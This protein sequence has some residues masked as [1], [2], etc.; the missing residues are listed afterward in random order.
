MNFK[1]QW[2]H[3][4][5]TSHKFSQL[6]S[7]QLGI[8]RWFRFKM[9]SS[10]PVAFVSESLNVDWIR[11]LTDFYHQKC[12]KLRIMLSSHKLWQW[13]E[14]ICELLWPKKAILGYKH[15]M[16]LNPFSQ[17]EF[18]FFWLVRNGKRE[19]CLKALYFIRNIVMTF[20]KDRLS[21][22]QRR[23]KKSR[24]TDFYW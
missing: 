12:I 2:N 24:L 1:I 23:K 14:G 11:S 13:P 3:H 22:L 17:K 21:L 7:S 6:S 8:K 20:N 10:I 19:M 15:V 18:F 5:F 16:L 4:K 9:Y